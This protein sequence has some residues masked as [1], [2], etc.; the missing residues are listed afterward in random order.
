MSKK[1]SVGKGVSVVIP[2]WN[3][4]GLLEKNFA[5]VMRAKENIKNQICEVVVVDDASSDNSVEYLTDNWA[6]QIRIV[7]RKANKGFS[8]TVNMGVRVARGEFVCLLNQDVLPSRD[9]LVPAIAHF[10]SKRVFGVSFHERGYG[11]AIGKFEGGYVVHRGAGEKK[12]AY[13]SF[14]ANGGSSVFRKEIWVKLKG[15]DDGLFDPF[16]WEDIDICYRAQKRGY[17]IY[18]EPGAR[19]AHEHESVINESNFG[20]K[21]MNVIKERN[22]LLFVWKNITSPRLI[23]KHWI[24]LIKRLVGHPGYVV[25]LAAALKKR[26]MAMKLREIEKRESAISD[27]AI[28]AR[29]QN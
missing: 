16:Y 17:L 13:L 29:F 25:V 1:K 26:G 23:R 20:F 18:W 28:F 2:V 4:R 6:G 27:E 8:S 9:F 15:L 11:G 10:E 21:R 22:Q 12:K 24:G 7:R 19:V 14:W 3:G 5:G